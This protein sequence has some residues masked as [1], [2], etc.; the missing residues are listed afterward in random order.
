MPDTFSFDAGACYPFAPSPD[1]VEG[2][3]HRARIVFEGS[4]GR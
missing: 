3:L 1:L 2:T 4:H